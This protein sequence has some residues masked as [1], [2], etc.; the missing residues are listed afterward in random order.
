MRYEVL[1]LILVVLLGSCKHKHHKRPFLPP[2]LDKCANGY[3]HPATDPFTS[4]TYED[5]EKSSWKLKSALLNDKDYT[6]NKG[7]VSCVKVQGYTC[8]RKGRLLTFYASSIR[9][10]QAPEAV[11]LIPGG[12]TLPEDFFNSSKTYLNNA[13][14]VLS[15]KGY[16]VYSP[17]VTHIAGFQNAQR[18]LA[19]FRGEDAFKVDVLRTVELLKAVHPKYRQIH[20]AGT[21][22]GGLLAVR[23]YKELRTHYPS[24]ARKVGA[25]LS[26][27]G[28][29]TAEAI[30]ARD[31][32]N[33]FLPTYE[34]VYPGEPLKD[35]RQ[36]IS[37]PNV[38]MAHSTCYY[39]DWEPTY[40][41][42]DKPRNVIKF[43]G[44]H[45]FR[46]DIFLS[47]LAK[48]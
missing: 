7:P 26:I 10:Q 22:Y 37:L 30:L 17:Y 41:G 40:L 31:P 43:V 35:Y 14:T 36:M 15:K 6:I 48:Y 42:K 46:P 9:I 18:R 24:I 45:E 25:V 3:N 19:A 28:Y 20:I 32:K 27:E 2:V 1:L 23:V 13:G 38:Y 47:I 29:T 4:G 39:K 33:L 44:K 8:L 16:D 5:V 34:M 11:I 12:A 21:S